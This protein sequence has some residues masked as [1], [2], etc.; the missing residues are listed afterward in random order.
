VS[1]FLYWND[2]VLSNGKIAGHWVWGTALYTAGLVTVLGKAALITNIWTKYAVI[3]IPGSLAVW[4]IFLPVYATVAPMAGISP[5]YIG[6]LPV[7]FSDPKFWLMAIVLPV[8]CLLR[9]LAWKYAKR[10]YFPQSYHHVQEIQKY[11]IQ[12]YRPRYVLNTIRNVGYL[13]TYHSE[14]SNSKRPFAKCG[15]SSACASSVDT[16]SHRQ[17]KVKPVCYRLTIPRESA[18]DMVKCRAV[19]GSE[20]RW[21]M[22]PKRASASIVKDLYVCVCVWL[23]YH[24][25]SMPDEWHSQKEGHRGWT[26]VNFLSS[27]G[28]LDMLEAI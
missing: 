12:D 18:V 2:G 13:L 9:D 26:T 3:A 4:F 23:K 15:K 25:V 14:W 1:E 16:L 28:Y 11:N 5:E 8:L 7:L 21:V 10:M 6:V 19:D 22:I 24:H 20:R 17:T 27:D